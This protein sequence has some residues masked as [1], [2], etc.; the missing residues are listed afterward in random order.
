MKKITLVLIML[1]TLLFTIN[2]KADGIHAIY[3]TIEKDREGELYNLMPTLVEKGEIISVKL[4]VKEVQGWKLSYGHNIISWDKEAFELVEQPNGKYYIPKD[5]HLTDIG[6][7]V[8]E[9]GNQANIHY[10]YDGSIYEANES[11]VAEIQF[12][13]KKNVKEGVYFIK[14]EEACDAVVVEMLDNSEESTYSYEKKLKYQVGKPKVSSYFTRDDIANSS[15]VIGGYLFTRDGSDAYDGT[16]TTEHIM[17]SSKS[18]QENELDKMIIYVKNARGKW[19]NA[20]SD[21]EF[22][23]DLPIENLPENFNIDYIDMVAHY[24]EDGIYT[25]DGENTVLR[26]VQFNDKKAVVTIETDSERVHGIANITNRVATLSISGINY[27]ITLSDNE[28]TIETN[29]SYIVNRVLTKRANVSVNEY[30]NNNYVFGIYDGTTGGASYYMNSAETGKYTY[31]NYELDVIKVSESTIRACLKQKGQSNCIIDKYSDIPSGEDAYQFALE[32]TEYGFVWNNNEFQG[33]CIGGI[34]NSSYIGTYTKEKSLSIEDVFNIWEKNEI[35][36]RVTYDNGI[37]ED[38]NYYVYIPR[39]QSVM[40]VD[41]YAGTHQKEGYAFIEWQ[42]N[43]QPYNFY[44]PVNAPITLVATYRLLPSA[45]TLAIVPQSN[46]V[47]YVSYNSETEKFTYKLS[48]TL[49]E[50]YYGYDIFID[51]NC[52][53]N[54]LKGETATIELEARHSKEVFAK[55]YILNEDGKNYGA[56]SNAVTPNV[57]VYTVTFATPDVYPF[58]TS[59]HV[60]YNG[61]VEPAQ[62][63]ARNFFTFTG[64]TLNNEPF[65]FENT[66]I[67]ENVTLTATWDENIPVPVIS[68]TPTNDAYRYAFWMENHNDYCTNTEGVCTRAQ[69]DNYG[70]IKFKLYKVTPGGYEELN[71]GYTYLPSESAYVYVPANAVNQ[72][73]MRAYLYVSYE[74]DVIVYSDY[75]EVFEIDTTF[76]TAPTIAFNPTYGTPNLEAHEAENWVYVSNLVSAFGHQCS[77]GTCSDYKVDGFKLYN[78]VGEDYL[79][80]ASFNPTNAA[81][82][83]V[84]YGEEYHYYVRGYANSGGNTVYTPYSTELVYNPDI[85]A[86]VITRALMGSGEANSNNYQLLSYDDI[87]GFGVTL[88][89]N[90]SLHYICDLTDPENPT[91]CQETVDEYEWFEKNG[92]SLTSV[93][94]GGFGAEAILYVPESS[95]KTFVAKAYV[96]RIN[97]GKYYSPESNQIAIDLSNPT[98]T[99]VT[100]D[101]DG[102]N[103]KVM[104]KGFINSYGIAFNTINN[105]TNDITD[106]GTGVYFVTDKTNLEGIDTITI[107]L[108]N[109]KTV[110]AT[111][112]SN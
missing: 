12:R 58:Q 112:Q 84:N 54:A 32:D 103:T 97:N 79:E 81:H 85:P 24:A 11:Y 25:D 29:D 61:L 101:V 50:D 91:N 43:N 108:S 28:A 65:D 20:I 35:L 19:K 38:G 82:V 72:Y 71:T 63:P 75:S 110:T 9:G 2:V 34:C 67:N 59:V 94:D 47:D 88:S 51:G 37:E 98:Y 7:E 45:P 96:N 30:L 107:K 22:G 27:Q 102:D 23:V 78:K 109:S 69:G 73:V 16:L 49:D 13:A 6:L 95:S 86:P 80:I 18:I 40:S 52:V 92:G 111:R 74:P 105:G 46:D 106:D 14:L 62:A 53:A 104:V 39:G 44:S 89:G 56:E 42:L 1:F 21:K 66:R 99:F 70:N 5:S 68:V 90:Y 31:G 10:G 60:P 48:I 17:L 87:K 36:Y 77:E 26:I 55:A 15:Y 33:Q 8:R 83:I 100:Q 41:A 57:T 93:Y 76:N 3:P 64:W 4:K